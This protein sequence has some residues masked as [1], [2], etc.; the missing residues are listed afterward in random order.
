VL[1]PLKPLFRDTIVPVH[2]ARALVLDLDWTIYSIREIISDC[3]SLWLARTRIR[4][5]LPPA[6]RVEPLFTLPDVYV[7]RSR[8][9]AFGSYRVDSIKWN[10]C[11]WN[12]PPAVSEHHV[13]TRKTDIGDLPELQLALDS[14]KCR[15]LW[16]SERRRSNK[17]R[18]HQKDFGDIDQ[19]SPGSFPESGNM[20]T[21][22]N[23]TSQACHSSWR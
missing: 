11:S 7:R 19:G 6:H 2:L 3:P 23:R 1:T 17:S 13:N 9:V 20:G 15:G 14:K 16:V 8:L 22:M 4:D 18:V 12:D 5:S 10:T 21:G